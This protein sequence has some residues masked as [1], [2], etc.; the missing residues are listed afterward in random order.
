MIILGIDPGS[1]VTGYG[2]VE[3]S[4]HHRLIE[5]GCIRP[6][7]NVSFERRLLDIHEQFQDLVKRRRPDAVAVEAVFHGANVQTLMKMCHARGT[8]LTAV[9]RANVPFFEYAPREVK[10]A[11]VGNGNAAKEQVQFMVEKVLGPVG[12]GDTPLDVTDAVAV[13]LCHAHRSGRSGYYVGQ[14]NPSSM[15]ERL[16]AA[17]AD[18]AQARR[19]AK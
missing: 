17:G 4:R 1:V 15:A 7:T 2:Y 10:K 3:T 12:E 8:I 18:P 16:I 5:A 14:R 11:V 19:F 6:V 9:A 13:A